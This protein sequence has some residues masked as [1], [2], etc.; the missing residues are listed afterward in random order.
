LV[1]QCPQCGA[2]IEA[3]LAEYP[4]CG[5]EF[6][7]RLAPGAGAS[8]IPETAPGDLEWVEDGRVQYLRAM[9]YRSLLRWI[10]TDPVR[11]EE[12]RRARGYKARL[13]MARAE[14]RGLR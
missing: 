9:P 13:E 4:E 2:V 14:Q 3:G 7:R 12:A 11:A 6:V 10:G 5:H 1:R 8:R